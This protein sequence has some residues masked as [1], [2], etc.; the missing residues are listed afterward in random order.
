[1]TIFSAIVVYV[2]VWWALFFA[3]LPWG[4]RRVENAEKGHDD[5]AP[6]NPRLWTKLGVTTLLSVPVFLAI[7]WVIV[8]DLIVLR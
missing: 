7:R 4:I 6:V 2:I 3:I 5:G 1:M 8:S